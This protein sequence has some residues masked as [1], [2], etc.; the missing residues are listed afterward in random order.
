[1]TVFRVHIWLAKI[2]EPWKVQ[3]QW[4]TVYMFVLIEAQL[5]GEDLYHQVGTLWEDKEE[6]AGAG[7]IVIALRY[8]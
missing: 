4:G 6:A 7:E 8:R 3:V 1:M 5:Q 2:R